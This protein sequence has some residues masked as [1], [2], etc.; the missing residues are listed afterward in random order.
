MPS[1]EQNNNNNNNNRFFSLNGPISYQLQIGGGDGI[2]A[3]GLLR[4]KET[5]TET[6]TSRT[7]SQCGLAV[8]LVVLG[9]KR[10]PVKN[11]NLASKLA[12]FL[13]LSLSLS[14]GRDGAC[15]K[16]ATKKLSVL[17]FC[18]SK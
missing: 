9:P 13:S 5:E 16:A 4:D 3:I 11:P 2:L 17:L 15:S 8:C 12:N 1:N 7:C 6:H 14:L 18:I 10:A